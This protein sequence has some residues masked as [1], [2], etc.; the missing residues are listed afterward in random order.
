MQ[1]VGEHDD[2]E[3]GG[4]WLPHC[5]GT[6]MADCRWAWKPP[7][8]NFPTCYVAATHAWPVAAGWAIQK[9]TACACL[10]AQLGISKQPGRV[11]PCMCAAS[12]HLCKATI[13]V[14]LC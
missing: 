10:A 9:G 3:F 5:P 13:L 1:F 4:S 7:C 14:K 8:D 12:A 2:G 11:C 6:N